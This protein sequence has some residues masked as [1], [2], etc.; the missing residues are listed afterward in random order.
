[1][2]KRV[3]KI[4]PLLF[5]C[6]IAVGQSMAPA[7]KIVDAP[8]KDTLNRVINDCRS[9]AKLYIIDGVAVLPDITR[10]DGDCWASGNFERTDIERLP[11]NNINYI[12]G[13]FPR[14]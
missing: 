10:E 7:V 11:T 6:Q 4:L 12:L 9:S 14:H 3:W 5:F 2:L 1:M 8:I 13:F